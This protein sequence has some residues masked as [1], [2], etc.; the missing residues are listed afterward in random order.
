MAQ[1]SRVPAVTREDYI[2]AMLTVAIA[3][4]QFIDEVDGGHVESHG[5]VAMLRKAVEAYQKVSAEYFAPTRELRRPVD[6]TD[7]I[8]AQL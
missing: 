4:E 1:E 5:A 2:D 8:E 3:A 6:V 7:R